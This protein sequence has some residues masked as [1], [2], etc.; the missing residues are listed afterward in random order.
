MCNILFINIIL[1]KYEYITLYQKL[2]MK[3][4]S[5]GN[6]MACIANGTHQMTLIITKLWCYFLNLFNTNILISQ[7]I[8]LIH[9][10]KI[11]TK[12]WKKKTITI[13]FLTKQ[14]DNPIKSGKSIIIHWNIIH[15]SFKKS[16]LSAIKCTWWWAV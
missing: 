14:Y 13:I 9:F 5:N 3:L 16:N 15:S 4:S 7:T 10:N 11:F 6:F 12:Y 1:L 2:C 8:Y